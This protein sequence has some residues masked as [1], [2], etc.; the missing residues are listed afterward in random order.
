MINRNVGRYLIGGVIVLIFIFLIPLA[1]DTTPER[2]FENV[3]FL[4]P[5]AVALFFIPISSYKLKEWDIHLD[6]ITDQ[7]TDRFQLTV[8]NFGET[9]FNFNRIS[10]VSYKKYFLFGE[11]IPWPS[12][13]IFGDEIELHGADTHSRILHEHMGY[14]VKLGMPIVIWIRPGELSDFINH[15]KKPKIKIYFEGTDQS[16]CSKRIPKELVVRFTA[17]QYNGD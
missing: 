7:S 13:G 9:P 10:F 16:A 3:T 4:I 5:I 1:L 14:T 17:H 8:S 12:K 11:R 15:Y 2:Y 6:F